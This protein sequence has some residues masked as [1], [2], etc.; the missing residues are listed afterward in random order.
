MIYTDIPIMQSPQIQMFAHEVD[1]LV[2]EKMEHL[3][4]TDPEVAKLQEKV[5]VTTSLVSKIEKSLKLAKANCI[6]TGAAYERW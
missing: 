4:E 3:T 6:S 2:L 1:V 5:D